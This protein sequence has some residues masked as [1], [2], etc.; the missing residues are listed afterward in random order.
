VNVA[1][2]H[3]WLTP[4]LLACCAT[5][6]AEGGWSSLW[7]TPDQRG[8]AQLRDGDAAAA[9]RS[10][11]DPRRRAYAQ[12]K[13]GD[14]RA[15]AETYATLDDADAHYNRGNA[16]A[17]TGE[18]Q[19]ALGAY[20]A[21]LAKNPADRD[22]RRNRDLVAQ[23]LQQP[24]AR[25]G[26]GPKPS[27]LGGGPGAQPPAQAASG[28]PGEAQTARGSAATQSPGSSAQPIDGAADRSGPSDAREGGSAVVSPS[29]TATANGQTEGP[30][31]DQARADDAAQ[32]QRDVFGAVKRPSGARDPRDARPRQRS[33]QQLAEDQ[34]LRRL[35]DDP[36]GLLR[37]KFLIQHLIRQGTPP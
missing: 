23:A 32:A 18:L 13:S 35:P 29:G 34:W 10:Y 17:R 15:A 26:Q 11:A 7:R 30:G 37:R 28:P 2:R 12:M 14:F 19:Q 8:E 27:A 6:H 4:L 5:A 20:D 24:S 22:A 9:A 3:L 33:E 16:L 1:S 36:A 31:T 21:A 25:S